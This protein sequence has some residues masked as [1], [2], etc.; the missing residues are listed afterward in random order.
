MLDAALRVEFP[1][2]VDLYTPVGAARNDT[3]YV[4]TC[5][6]GADNVGIMTLSASSASGARSGKAI[7]V[8][9]ALQSAAS[10]LVRWNATGR[11][12]GFT[13]FVAIRNAA[14]H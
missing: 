1:I 3:L 14:R 4:E 6:I 12:P 7:R 10:P 11:S 2:M 9:Q 13:E 5:E 8:S